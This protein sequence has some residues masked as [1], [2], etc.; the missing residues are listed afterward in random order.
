MARYKKRG[1]TTHAD[2]A[3]NLAKYKLLTDKQK[4]WISERPLHT[5]DKS[6]SEE[7]ELEQS[8]IRLWRTQDGFRALEQWF[9]D[10]PS[11][12]AIARRDVML[13]LAS[14]VAETSMQNPHNPKAIE[15][16]KFA[17]KFY[18]DTD[19]FVSREKK[20]FIKMSPKMESD[21]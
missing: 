5:S 12:V 18:G 8:N 2:Y 21:E 15:A 10:D 3:E 14:R 9:L 17:F 13:L 16:M 1:D 6:C 11:R 20:K 7:L 4:E 19:V